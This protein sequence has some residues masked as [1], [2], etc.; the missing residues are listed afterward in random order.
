MDDAMGQMTFWEDGQR[1]GRMM[2]LS[3]E[4]KRM[5]SWEAMASWKGRWQHG[6]VWGCYSWVNA[7]GIDDIRGGLGG[8]MEGSARAW[9]SDVILDWSGTDG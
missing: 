5:T 3:L 1:N 6:R 7:M 4:R 8:I 9:L 2:S